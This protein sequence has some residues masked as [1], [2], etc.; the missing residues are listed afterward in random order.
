MTLAETDLEREIK[1]ISS[2]MADNQKIYETACKIFDKS[3]DVELFSWWMEKIC[4][5]YFKNDGYAH[6][7]AIEN[8][9]PQ[10]HAYLQFLNRSFKYRFLNYDVPLFL[11][12]LPVKFP[13]KIYDAVK[14]LR[15][16][17][18]VFQMHIIWRNTVL[19][20]ELKIWKD[21]TKNGCYA[22]PDPRIKYKSSLKFIP[23]KGR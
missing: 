5:E 12:R 3:P 23:V 21:M 20:K 2:S 22:G 13:Y 19:K 17:L 8:T 11:G 18:I 4:A 7:M 1:I 9:P 6:P 15:M 14:S 10:V 16:K